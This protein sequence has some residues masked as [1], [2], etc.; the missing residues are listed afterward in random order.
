[1]AATKPEQETTPA[2]R[3]VLLPVIE[4]ITKGMRLA[5]PIFN[6][7]HPAIALSAPEVGTDDRGRQGTIVRLL[8]QRTNL[9]GQPFTKVQ[10]VLEQFTFQRPDGMEG[11]LIDGIDVDAAV[12]AHA[13][14]FGDYLAERTDA[15]TVS[16][17]PAAEQA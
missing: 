3:P 4:A 9:Q 10:K 8:V 17:A 11:A 1:M 13:E 7:V 14:R 12:T 16:Q 15:A 2:R 5:W 6:D